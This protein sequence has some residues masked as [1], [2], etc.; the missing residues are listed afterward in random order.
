MAPGSRQRGD[1]PRRDLRAPPRGAHPSDAPRHAGDRAPRRARRRSGDH[2]L[3]SGRRRHRRPPLGAAGAHRRHPPRR[4]TDRPR[5]ARARASPAAWG[6]ARPADPLRLGPP[7]SQEPAPPDRGVRPPRRAIPP[8]SSSSPATRRPSRTRS[9][10]GRR[11]LGVADRVRFLG[12]VTDED[13]EGLY[14]PPACFAFPSLAEG[15]GL[16]VL[17]AMQ[18]G[19]PVA[20]SDAA[21]LPRSAATRSGYFDPLDV[22]ARSPRRSPI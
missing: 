16:P 13:L 15:F 22:S 10:A 12:W 4:Q 21:P 1:H 11:S 19:A 20:T 7:P 8:L 3:A 5:D 6:S 17:E 18:R 14:A 2:H 9:G